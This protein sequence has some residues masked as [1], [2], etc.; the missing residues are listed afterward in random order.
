[1]LILH[2]EVN[3]SVHKHAT[4]YLRWLLCDK[5]EAIVINEITVNV[6]PEEGIKDYS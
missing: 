3:K 2:I 6:L 4:R 1:M 5:N